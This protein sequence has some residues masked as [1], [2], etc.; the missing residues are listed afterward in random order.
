LTEVMA[1]MQTYE[2]SHHPKDVREPLSPIAIQLRE[3]RSVIRP[4]S[5]IVIRL[6]PIDQ[7]DRFNLCIDSILTW[8]NRRAG[9]QLPE[10]AWQRQSFELSDIG[11]QRTAAVSIKSPRYWAARLD[12]AD[13]SVVMRT[14]VTEIGVGVEASGDVLF[15]TRLICASRGIDEP[16][17]RTVPGF[18]RQ[19]LGAGEAELDGLTIY[20]DARL[21]STESDV[22]ALV[23][24]L[25]DTSRHSDVLVL[26]L[27]EGSTDPSQTAVSANE[28]QA[29][30]V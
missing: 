23:S 26:A 27:P 24:L 6:K 30:L 25:E 4:V 29:K 20:Q 19:V 22:G 10:L 7:K 2:M 11:A 5:Q 21:V 18:V 1:L 13:K 28:L 14:W 3:S 16:Y 8:M 17:K 15:G 9:C 12:D